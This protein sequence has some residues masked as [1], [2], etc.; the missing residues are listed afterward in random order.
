MIKMQE[1]FNTYSL[2]N[3]YN[4]LKAREFEL[5]EIVDETN[6]MNFGGPLALVLKTTIGQ[7]CSDDKGGDSDEG[8][9]M[10]LDGLLFK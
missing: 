10:N 1:N 2:L 9:M 3:L 7:V 4:I 6:K 5:K 8:L